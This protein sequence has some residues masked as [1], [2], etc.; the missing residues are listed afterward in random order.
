MRLIKL[1][2]SGSNLRLADGCILPDEQVA[3]AWHGKYETHGTYPDI[4]S[5]ETIQSKIPNRI[6]QDYEATYQDVWLALT[7]FTFQLVRN[8]DVTGV[9]GTGVV[10]AGC[11]FFGNSCVLQWT[12]EVKSTFWYPSLEVIKI[13]HSHHGKTRIV[14]KQGVT[15]CP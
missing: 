2:D 14:D 9:S 6:I 11:E 10:A 5:F 8:E 3:I 15:L 12:G 4:K 7:T 1:V 13:L